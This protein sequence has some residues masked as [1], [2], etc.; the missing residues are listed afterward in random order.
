V[1]RVAKLCVDFGEYQTVFSLEGV[2]RVNQFVD[3]PAEMAK[4]EQVLLPRPGQSRRQKIQV[5]HGLGGIGKTQLTVEFARRHN[6][7]FSSVLWL[8]GRSE[9]SLRRSITSCAS[10]IP[11]GQI[12][13]TSR[14]YSADGSANIDV[15]VKDV[16]DWL[17][18][19]DNTAWLLIIDNV[20]REYSPR[21]KDPD[22]Y[23]VKDYL[24]GAD[25]GSVLITTRLARLEQLG[26][27]QQLGKVDKDQGRAIFESWY[28]RTYGKL[29][30][31]DRPI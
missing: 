8:D 10:R 7:R 27:S 20:D 13:E 16:M 12:P 5:L 21:S 9:D 29:R 2:P 11:Q 31:T 4:L 28:K 26:D 25:H 22:A 24:S 1:L 18:Q 15:V 17:A 19:T 30:T 14:A 23:D 3:R 6:R